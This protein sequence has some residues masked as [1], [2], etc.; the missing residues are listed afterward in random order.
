MAAAMTPEQMEQMFN[1]FAARLDARLDERF[2][3]TS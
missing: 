2:A 1:T 3:R